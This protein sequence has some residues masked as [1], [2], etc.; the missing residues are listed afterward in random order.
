MRD[1]IGGGAGDGVDG[2]DDDDVARHT[3]RKSG[4]SFDE[5]AR[6]LYQI[7]FVQC[8]KSFLYLHDLVE[9]L[10]KLAQLYGQ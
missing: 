5:Y 6:S 10:W 1:D 2:D 8:Q 7:L 3:R 9:I 4:T